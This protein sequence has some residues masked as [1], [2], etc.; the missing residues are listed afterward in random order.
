MLNEQSEHNK[1]SSATLIQSMDRWWA[2]CI[3]DD[4]ERKWVGE[5]IKR[6]RTDE[7]FVFTRDLYVLAI[8][9]RVETGKLSIE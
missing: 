3:R 4:E 2:N 5:L 1:L 9:R 8:D 6:V 7:D